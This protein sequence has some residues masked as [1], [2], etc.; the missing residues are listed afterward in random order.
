MFS[1]NPI[2]IVLVIARP[3]TAKST[4]QSST[5]RF[6][7]RSSA[8][9]NPPRIS[10]AISTISATKLKPVTERERRDAMRLQRQLGIPRQGWLNHNS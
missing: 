1:K 5:L 7:A 3:Q 2:C 8:N 4:H 9:N 6:S 10:S